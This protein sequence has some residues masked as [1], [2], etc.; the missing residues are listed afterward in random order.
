MKVISPRPPHWDYHIYFCKSEGL[1]ELQNNLFL[2]TSVGPLCFIWK[3]STMVKRQNCVA[4]TGRWGLNLWLALIP[5]QNFWNQLLDRGWARSMELFMSV[6]SLTF[7]SIS[8]KSNEKDA[9][10]GHI[11]L[12]LA[13]SPFSLYFFFLPPPISYAYTLWGRP[14]LLEGIWD[15]SNLV[16]PSSFPEALVPLSLKG[17][18]KCHV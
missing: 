2:A 15:S 9:I 12:T 6:L 18:L 5:A 14:L 7:F 13:P 8:W 4:K 17:H 3:F 1:E 16:L 11:I 10:E